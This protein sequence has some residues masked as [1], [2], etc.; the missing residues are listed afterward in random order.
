MGKVIN[1][2]RELDRE[3]K[4]KKRNSIVMKCLF[5]AVLVYILYA[6]FLIVKTPNNTLIVESGV[7]T[8][9]E[10]VTGVVIR[11][12]VTVQ[13]NNYKNGIYQILTEGE[14][15]A[16]NQIIFRY[17]GNEEKE[18]QEK[19]AEVDS[20]IQEALEKEKK[21]IFSADVKKLDEKIDNITELLSNKT[22]IQAIT[23]YKK[24]ISEIM[25]KKASIIGESSPSGSYIKKLISQREKYKNELEK[26]SEYIK[27]P[28]SGIVS[29]RVD[30][31]E[32]VLGINNFDNLTSSKL[33]ELEIKTG[34]IVAANSEKGKVIDN[35]GCYI[36]AVL[37]S[38]TAKE[39]KEYNRVKITLASNKEVNAEVFKIKQENDK[40]LVIFKITTL[41]D[42]IISYRKISFNITWWSYSG[43]KVPNEAIIEDKDGLEYVE[44]KT[45]T[46][47]NKVLIKVLKRN[48]RYSVI[49]SYSAEDLKELGI[50]SSSYKGI[51]MHDTIMLYPEK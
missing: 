21:S 50:D 43:I 1:F 33:D 3:K 36:V 12:E 51:S 41:T 16:K 10:S 18:L 9:E 37:D 48:E 46:G 47:K 19:I 30:G 23:E 8:E 7:L 5:A 31:L 4:R 20:K 25:I 34:K 2:E 45:T 26:D 28:M 24:N 40:R 22:D 15:T 44:K 35:F 29:Y 39:A 49:G 27:A 13:G 6:I 38:N 14:K 32:E 17:Y 11:N 42:D